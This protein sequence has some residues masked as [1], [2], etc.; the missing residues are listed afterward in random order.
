MVT[1]ERWALKTKKIAHVINIIS[2]VMLVIYCFKQ[3]YDKAEYARDMGLWPEQFDPDSSGWG[4]K[5]TAKY[6]AIAVLAVALPVVLMDLICM[7]VQAS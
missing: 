5:L 3:G 6:L 7:K 1:A 4:K 2:F